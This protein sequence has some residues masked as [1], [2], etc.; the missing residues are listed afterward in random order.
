[1]NQY[2]AVSAILNT[3]NRPA[4]FRRALESIWTQTYRDMEVLVIYDGPI[5]DETA[6]ICDEYHKL[7][8]GQDINFVVA[9]LDENSGYQCVPKNVGILIAKGDYIA[10][11]D[12]DNEWTPDHLELL[13]TA[14]EEGK[15]WPD[16]VYGRRLYIDER[17]DKS[18]KKLMTGPSQFV[19]WNQA[20]E[21]RLGSSAANN[22]IDTSDT[23]ISRGAFWRL[24]MATDMMWNETMRR[25]G[26]YEMI[27][28]GVFFAG[29]RGKAINHIVQNYYWHGENLQL[30]RPANE[31]PRQQS[32]TAFDEF[33]N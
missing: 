6:E 17:E 23:L 14:M 15:I 20:A 12:D 18:G 27:T 11:L 26:D 31:V 3:Y 10:F 30:T 29:W 1:M 19:E 28:R 25:F 8:E 2:P 16:F 24:Q 9:G 13:V 7:F 33:C 21:E 5:D 4:K 32:A 22:F